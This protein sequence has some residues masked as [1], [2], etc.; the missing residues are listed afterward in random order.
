VVE[1]D[2]LFVAATT[3]LDSENRPDYHEYFDY[4]TFR[5]YNEAVRGQADLMV[6]GMSVR[7]SISF[8]SSDRTEQAYRQYLSGNVFPTFGL[9]PALG[10]LLTPSDD[11]RPGAHPVAILS[12]DYWRRR[13]ARDPAVIGQT[14]RVGRQQYEII[15]VSPKGFTG[16]EPGRLVDFFIPAMMNAQAINSPGWSWFR[17]WVRPKPGVIAEQVRQQLQVAFLQ[18]H[19]DRLGTFSSD[20]PRQQ[21]DAYMS[22]Q[23]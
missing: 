21:I 15:G 10:R 2:R 5:R 7:Q 11:E 14:F 23:V 12:Y 6:V 18:D 17:M 9:Q 19:R 8:G 22:E 1:P 20:T 16:T 3:R 13:F 4:P